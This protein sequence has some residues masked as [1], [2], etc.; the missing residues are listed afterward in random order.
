M[1]A[2]QGVGLR[3]QMDSFGVRLGYSLNCYDR[4]QVN[5]NSYS[6]VLAQIIK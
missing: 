3:R 5:Y 6:P 2:L 1:D 4:V